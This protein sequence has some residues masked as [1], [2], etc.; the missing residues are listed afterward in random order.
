MNGIIRPKLVPRADTNHPAGRTTIARG[1]LHSARARCECTVT[2]TGWIQDRPPEQRA[3]LEGLQ[4]TREIQ[5]LL[6][7]WE[8]ETVNM[9]LAKPQAKEQAPFPSH[10]TSGRWGGGVR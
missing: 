5:G 3:A 6:A 2:L 1:A 8:Q 10:D 7:V 4:P 9:V